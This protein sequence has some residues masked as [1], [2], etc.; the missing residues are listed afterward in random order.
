MQ[1]NS[2]VRE[3]VRLPIGAMLKVL[4]LYA[5]SVAQVTSVTN[6]IGGPWN[7]TGTA[8]TVG[9][10]TQYVELRLESLGGDIGFEVIPQVDASLVPFV[11]AS[12][13]GPSMA[14]L[15]VQA[16]LRMG[17]IFPEA[18]GA[19]GD[20]TSHPLSAYFPTLAKAQEKYGVAAVALSDEIDGVV[21]QAMINYGMGIAGRPGGNY[22]LTRGVQLATGCTGIGAKRWSG[23]ASTMKYMLT[24]TLTYAGAGGTDSYVVLASTQPV[25]ILPTDTSTRAL[26]N[27]TWKGWTID[28][29][30]TAWYGLIEIR[31][32]FGNDFSDLT[33]TNCRVCHNVMELGFV[34]GSDRRQIFKGRG[35]GLL[36]GKDLWSWGIA[37]TSDQITFKDWIISFMGADQSSNYYNVF[38]DTGGSAPTS[39]NLD[40]ECGISI[41]GARALKFINCQVLKCGGPGLVC[42]PTLTGP[43]VIDG[44]YFEFNSNSTNSSQRWATWTTTVVGSGPVI[45]RDISFSGT[46]PAHRITGTQTS[47]ENTG[48]KFVNCPLMGTVF[49]DHPGWNAIDCDPLMV[50]TGSLPQSPLITLGGIRFGNGTDDAVFRVYRVPAASTGLA[51]AGSTVAGTGW[52]TNPANNFITSDRSG[53]RVFVGG[54]MWLTTV[55]TGAT[56]SSR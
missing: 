17:N 6:G 16:F 55:G 38:A 53:R 1:I 34:T 52:V 19:V 28:G 32:A 51:V 26:Q 29:A 25:G 40:S 23:A 9:P 39:T 12:L 42:S 13:A 46:A 56:G 41:Y 44:G 10:F 14:A 2:L 5:Y 21:L 48:V 4:P 43:I 31:A 8:L 24:S 18:C 47:R 45:Y 37:T 35:A 30:D 11:P 7:M 36:I 15:S 3:V 27:V 50:V 54:Q 49:A 22:L 33:I 20:G